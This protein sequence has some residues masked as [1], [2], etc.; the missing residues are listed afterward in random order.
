MLA[1]RG[2]KLELILRRDGIDVGKYTRT[3]YPEGKLIDSEDI[4]TALITTKVDI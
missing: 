2:S 4:E 3:L 1:N